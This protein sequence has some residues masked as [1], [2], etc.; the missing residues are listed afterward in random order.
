MKR[1][2][3]VYI[4]SNEHMTLF[5]GVAHDLMRRMNEFKNRAVEGFRQETGLSKLLYYEEFETEA[6]A[7]ARE[8]QLRHWERDWKL[9][10]IKRTNPA[11]KDLVEEVAA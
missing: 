10:L 8:K 4:L 6:D 11:F 2:Y 1:N 7:V 5:I 9:K 3:F